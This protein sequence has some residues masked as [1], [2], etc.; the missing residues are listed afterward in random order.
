MRTDLFWVHIWKALTPVEEAVRALDDAVRAGTVLYV[1]VP[2]LP[3]CLVSRAS[4]PADPR[5][6]SPFIGLR[7][8]YSLARRFPLPLPV[9]SEDRQLD[10]DGELRPVLPA[11]TL[12]QTS[13]LSSTVNSSVS[14]T[15]VSLVEPPA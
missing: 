7:V 3:A 1:G 4:A 14:L 10:L 6:W 15:C 12:S 2:D 5:G 9:S 13:S 8:P 11:S